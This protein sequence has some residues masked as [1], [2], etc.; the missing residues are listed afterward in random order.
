M[1]RFLLVIGLIM[2]IIS[3]AHYSTSKRT[4]V[5]IVSQKDFVFYKN[6]KIIVS[7]IDGWPEAVGLLKNSLINS[8]FDMYTSKKEAAY[9]NID[10]NIFA[11]KHWRKRLYLYYNVNLR[12]IDKEGNI[13]MTIKNKDVFWQTEL[14]KF[15]DR[16]ANSIRESMIQAVR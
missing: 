10:G 7:S 16:I 15:T 9:Y 8:F 12:V 11:K 5:E 1:K 2:T 14:D 6:D 13:V 3:C 4:Q